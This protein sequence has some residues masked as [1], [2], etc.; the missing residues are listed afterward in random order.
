[1]IRVLQGHCHCGNI[2]VRFTTVN[3]AGQL[4][5]RRCTCSFC[6]R[7]GARAV[8]DPDGSVEIHVND[9]AQMLR[10]RFGLRSAD[11]LICRRCGIYVAAVMADA[12]QYYATLNANV[13]DTPDF[14]ERP[15]EPFDYSNETVEER[16]ARRRQRWTPVS[17]VTEGSTP[18]I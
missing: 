14:R 3:P 18:V 1:M 8:S 10:Y 6:S 9:A 12:D 11:F 4:R 13:F 2:E 17:R 7:H 15:A 16:C 5:L